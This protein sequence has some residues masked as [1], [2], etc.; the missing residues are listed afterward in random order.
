MIRFRD[1]VVP[2]LGSEALPE[3]LRQAPQSLRAVTVLTVHEHERSVMRFGDLTTQRQTNSRPLGFCGEK[4]DEKIGG[5]HNTMAFIFNEDLNA[6][7]FL[8]P[9]EPDVSMRFKRGIN[10]VVHQID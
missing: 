3:L 9:A 5:V 6:I 8:T 2:D 4:R 10:S 7:R 1:Y